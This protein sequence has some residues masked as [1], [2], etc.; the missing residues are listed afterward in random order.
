MPE[1]TAHQDFPKTQSDVMQGPFSLSDQ[2]TLSMPTRGLQTIDALVLAANCPNISSQT[3]GFV[4][5]KVA[6]EMSGHLVKTAQLLAANCPDMS[7][8]IFCLL[9]QTQ[10]ENVPRSC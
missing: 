8:K 1:N 3:S 6:S 2:P 5:T 10:L 7:S 9:P 4:S